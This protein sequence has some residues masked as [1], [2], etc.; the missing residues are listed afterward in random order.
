MGLI[1]NV[2]LAPII[3]PLLPFILL[4]KLFLSLAFLPVFIFFSPILIPLWFAK[5]AFRT[6]TCLLLLPFAPILIPLKVLR[7]IL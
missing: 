2:L 5:V 7:W 3:G 4:A 1:T 6:I